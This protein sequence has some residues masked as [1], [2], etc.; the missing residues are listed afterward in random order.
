MNTLKR[1][2]IWIKLR[3]NGLAYS[4]TWVFRKNE[5]GEYVHEDLRHFKQL[6]K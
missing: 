3:R 6:L 5:N 4:A 1:L 2:I